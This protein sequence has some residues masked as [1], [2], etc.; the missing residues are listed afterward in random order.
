[1]NMTAQRHE[2]KWF[3]CVVVSWAAEL[4]L[5]LAVFSLSILGKLLNLKKTEND[6]L[7]CRISLALI[8]I[9]VF[10]RSEGHIRAMFPFIHAFLSLFLFLFSPNAISFR[11]PKQQHLCLGSDCL[12]KRTLLS[13]FRSLFLFSLWL[14]SRFLTVYR[15][16]TGKNNS[17]MLA[18]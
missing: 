4:F 14:F 1:M 10:F 11:A 17:M 2:C 15:L 8:I 18:G 16:C 5:S 7:K 12:I 13:C 3:I 9:V 6:G